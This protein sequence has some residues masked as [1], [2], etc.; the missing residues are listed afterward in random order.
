MLA[1]PAEGGE[2]RR[3]AGY[4]LIRVGEGDVGGEQRAARVKRARGP[5]PGD[6]VE[7]GDGGTGQR[8]HASA[9]PAAAQANQR[10]GARGDSDADDTVSRH[11]VRLLCDLKLCPEAGTPHPSLIVRPELNEGTS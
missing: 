11:C 8:G 3:G 6:A 1:R 10:G 4:D 7:D 9:F 2:G 5:P